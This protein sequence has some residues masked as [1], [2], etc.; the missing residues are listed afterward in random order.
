MSRMQKVMAW[1]P[2][3]KNGDKDDDGLLK[4]LHLITGNYQCLAMHSKT[5][6]SSVKGWVHG[7]SS[8]RAG[9]I[10]HLV[11]LG[12]EH[13]EELPYP[14]LDAIHAAGRLLMDPKNLVDIELYDRWTSLELDKVT[15][16]GFN[17]YM[18]RR[19]LL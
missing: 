10:R 5:G 8:P 3:A 17:Q 18:Q 4:R 2:N 6:V 1:M 11:M 19:K 7:H 12:Y 14:D 13:H 16:L 9:H 15:Q